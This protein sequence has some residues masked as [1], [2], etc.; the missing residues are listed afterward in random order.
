MTEHQLCKHHTAFGL[1]I[2]N[3]SFHDDHDDLLFTTLNQI[4]QGGLAALFDRRQKA[5]IAALHLKV[6][7]R[8]ATFRDFAHAH[9]CFQ[10]GISCLDNDDYWKLC[11]WFV[12]GLF[13]LC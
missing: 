6:G 2:C 7:R 10:N 4:Q 9:V 5:M 3:K 1:A 13:L 8:C 12:V 11:C